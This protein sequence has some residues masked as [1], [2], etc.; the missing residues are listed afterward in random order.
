[1]NCNASLANAELFLKAQ[2]AKILEARGGI[3]PPIKVLQTFALP[4]G[5]RAPDKTP[6]ASDNSSLSSPAQKQKTHLPGYLPAVGAKALGLCDETSCSAS[7]CQKTHAHNIHNSNK[8]ARSSGGSASFGY[9][10]QH[11]DRLQRYFC[12]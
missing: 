8:F 7:P 4:L 3:E 5:D 9:H 11:S 12:K 2:P 10:T 6:F 1:L